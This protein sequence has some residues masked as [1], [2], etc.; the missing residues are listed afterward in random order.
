MASLAASA[1]PGS[2]HMSLDGLGGGSIGHRRSD[3]EPLSR[4][5]GRKTPRYRPLPRSMYSL[6]I[7]HDGFNTS[8]CIF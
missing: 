3:S 5:S 2:M 6:V 8:I 4:K 7:N 1:T